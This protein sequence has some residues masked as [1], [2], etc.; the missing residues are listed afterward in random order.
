M[1]LLYLAI[2]PRRL[3][4]SRQIRQIE[5]LV[6]GSALALRKLV[7]KIVAQR[8]APAHQSLL[9]MG[10]PS[11]LFLL[12]YQLNPPKQ[13]QAPDGFDL[14]GRNKQVGIR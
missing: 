12:V 1:L 13:C 4:P 6:D 2:Q 5:I 3:G 10:S 11:P 8:N 9:K 7:A 14:A